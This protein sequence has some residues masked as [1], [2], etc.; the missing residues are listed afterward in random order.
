MSLYYDE[1]DERNEAHSDAEEQSVTDGDEDLWDDVRD[2]SDHDEYDDDYVAL[3]LRLEAA[4]RELEAYKLAK[5]QQQKKRHGGRDGDEDEAMSVSGAG[6]GTSAIFLRI[7][8]EQAAVAAAA[9]EAEAIV[10]DPEVILAG[11]VALLRGL[12]DLATQNKKSGRLPV[13][14]AVKA[15]VADQWANFLLQRQEKGFAS[16]CDLVEQ[17]T[18]DAPHLLQQLCTMCDVSGSGGLVNA[19]EQLMALRPCI[20][21]KTAH[22][23][24]TYVV[25]LRAGDIDE[26][27]ERVLNNVRSSAAKESVKC[28]VAELLPV[29]KRLLVPYQAVF[30]LRCKR[31]KPSYA[32]QRKRALQRAVNRYTAEQRPRKAVEAES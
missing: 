22:A 17:V 29:A 23:F 15:H 13:Y 25:P 9:A 27:L 1:L 11:H 6:S 32:V 5:Q 14:A 3:Q 7:D 18:R 19:L 2:D 16:L 4:A 30:A 12:T 24:A 28:D 21:T 26:T 20:D 31:R 10:Y 8:A